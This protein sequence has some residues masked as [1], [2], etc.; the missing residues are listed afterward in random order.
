MD[1]NLFKSIVDQARELGITKLN[2][3]PCKGEPFMHPHIY[4]ILDYADQN[5]REVMFFTNATAINVEKLKQVSLKNTQMCISEYGSNE[6]GF[7]KLTNMRESTYRIYQRRLQELTQA[8][9]KYEI[10][11]RPEDYEFDYNDGPV[12][13]TEQFDTKSKCEYHHEPKVFANGDITF[14]IFAREEWQESQKIFYAN[15]NTTTLADAITH[16]LRYKFY[17]SQSLC[18]S[19]CSG[20]SRDCYVKTTVPSIRFIAKSKARYLDNP[21]PTDKQYQ[22][23]EHEVI[24]RTQQ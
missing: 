13:S 23:L 6:Q 19:G 16:P 2:L 20:F 1:L 7:I 3:T 15:L 9:I 8:N 17:D 14:C 10:H 22:E 21:E 12:V 5:M 11:Y 24:Q 18:A 4:E